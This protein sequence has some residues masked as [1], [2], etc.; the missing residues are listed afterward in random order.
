MSRKKKKKREKELNE[1]QT[2][3]RN[4]QTEEN[5]W[6]ISFEPKLPKQGT[7]LVYV[8]SN[9]TNINENFIDKKFA[10]LAPSEPLT[11]KSQ[12]SIKSQTSIKTDE[13]T[14]SK[15]LGAISSEK[16]SRRHES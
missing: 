11:S 13:I 4:A 3:A 16:K 2:F 7:K 1:I 5:P 15:E 8:H 12:I 9:S 10:D 6:N 14:L